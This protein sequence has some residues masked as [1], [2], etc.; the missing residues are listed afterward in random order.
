MFYEVRLFMGLDDVYFVKVDSN[1]LNELIAGLED[2]VA[3]RFIDVYCFA[4][5]EIVGVNRDKVVA[6]SYK[7]VKE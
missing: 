2:P 3:P 4:G 1:G 6:Y 7:E 5:N